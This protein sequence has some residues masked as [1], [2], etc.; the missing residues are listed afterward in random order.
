LSNKQ[1]K[2]VRIYFSDDFDAN[3]VAEITDSFNK[4]LPTHGISNARIARDSVDGISIVQ[5]AF[6][7]IIFFAGSEMVKGF[8]NSIGSDLKEKLIQALR[9]KKKPLAQFKI[10]YKNFTIEINA[11]PERWEEWNTIFETIDKA[12][13]AAINEIKKDSQVHGIMI[14]YDASVEGYWSVTKF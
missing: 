11:R 9:N 12:E 3:E 10:C 14:T 7:I 13:Q 8:F 6:L 4:I 2:E 1:D 5:T